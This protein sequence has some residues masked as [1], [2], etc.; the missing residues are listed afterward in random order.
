[1]LTPRIFIQHIKAQQ[2]AAYYNSDT[3][4]YSA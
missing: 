1:M 4:D 3:T 2:G